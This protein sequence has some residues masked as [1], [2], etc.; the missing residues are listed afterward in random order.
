MPASLTR[1]AQ[2]ARSRELPNPERGQGVR[3]ETAGYSFR[4]L[5]GSE[6]TCG[7]RTYWASASFVWRDKPCH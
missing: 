2:L 6:V 1:L 7:T 5:G 3:D 4:F